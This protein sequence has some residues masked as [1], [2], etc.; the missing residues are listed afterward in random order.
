MNKK[1]ELHWTSE[2]GEV[3]SNDNL[4]LELES[5]KALP[6]DADQIKTTDHFIQMW[7]HFFRYDF[8]FSLI[9]LLTLIVA[10]LLGVSSFL[11]VVVVG[12]YLNLHD[13]TTMARPRT[14]RNR[15]QI[16]HEYMLAF[17]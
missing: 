5:H 6:C 3:L 16:K 14:N 9:I 10:R 8:F 12:F 11:V 2:K 13:E 1:R 7:R 4:W 15:I 17:L